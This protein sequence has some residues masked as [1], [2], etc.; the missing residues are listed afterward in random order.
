[1][2][3]LS[4]MTMC[5][6]NILFVEEK[7]SVAY[8]LTECSIWSER[9]VCTRGANKGPPLPPK[10]CYF[11]V[12]KGG[13]FWKVVLEFWSLVYNFCAEKGYVLRWICRHVTRAPT[14][15]CSCRWGDKRPPQACADGKQG[16][17]QRKRNYDIWLSQRYPLNII[18]DYNLSWKL[19][20]V[21]CQFFMRLP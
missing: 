11:W 1:M 7:Q 10:L 8:A 20:L 18:S 2:Y 15:F 19:V 13:Y 12:T 16:A 17:H 6:A 5:I 3:T 14:N 21:G 4:F 9:S